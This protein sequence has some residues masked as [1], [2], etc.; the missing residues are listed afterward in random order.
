MTVEVIGGGTREQACGE[1]LAE[2]GKECV[3]SHAIVLPIPSSRNGIDI[4]GTDIPLSRLIPLSK[5]GVVFCT[6]A[7]PSVFASE[8]ASRGG[9]VAD[10]AG[11]EIFEEA[12]AALTAECTL[13]YI[14]KNN[15]WA[16]RDLK[17]GIVGYGRIGRT[18]LEL[19][20][21]HGAEVT[22]FTR[23]NSTRVGLSELGVRAELTSLADF[24]ELDIL[25]NTA[26]AKLF[27]REQCESLSG[28]VLELAPGEN[29]AYCEN[30]TKLPSL[31]GKMT[32]RSAGRLYAEAVLRA[33]E[34]T[35]GR[36]EV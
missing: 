30:V 31:P 10:V 5:E 29:F 17:I 14:M 16:I 32:P 22:V 9:V 4:S 20:L 26:P 3:I 27:T 36:G 18:L 15:E 12:N 11:D 1:F 33:L 21:F 28:V 35:E 6:Y 19:L 13:S 7:T 8:I 2:Y 23:K 34:K 25:V 24:S